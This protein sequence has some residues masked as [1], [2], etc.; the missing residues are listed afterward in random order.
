[1]LALPGGFSYGDDI[2]SGRVLANELRTTLG[3]ALHAFVDRGGYIIGICN[4]FQVL[5]KSGLFI[6]VAGVREQQVTL[7]DNTSGLYRSLGTSRW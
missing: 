7:T 3:E 4:G 6:T 2:A 5:V 1:M